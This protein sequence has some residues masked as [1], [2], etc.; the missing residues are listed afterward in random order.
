MSRFSDE[1]LPTAQ[2]IISRYPVA[3]SAI[4]PLLHLAQEQAGYVTDEAMAVEPAGWAG[5]FVSE[6][7]TK[8][9]QEFD[10]YPQF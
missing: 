7:K 4:I 2:E 8:M 5:R 3:K 9:I 6:G 10:G 1:H